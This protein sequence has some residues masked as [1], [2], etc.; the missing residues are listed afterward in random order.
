MGKGWFLG[1]DV[2][3]FL[4]NGLVWVDEWELMGDTPYGRALREEK[5]YPWLLK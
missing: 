2:D 4:E 1:G 5:W 3:F